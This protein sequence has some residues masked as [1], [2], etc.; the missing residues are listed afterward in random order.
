MMITFVK[1][2]C[3][4]IVNLIE[5]F[6]NVLKEST[7][8][9]T[10]IKQRFFLLLNTKEDV[11]KYVGNQTDLVSIDFH[12]IFPHTMKVNGYQHSAHHRA[13]SRHGQGHRAGS[14]HGH[15]L[16]CPPNQNVGKDSLTHFYDL[17]ID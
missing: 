9:T 7:L 6:L 1:K 15:R 12:S 4:Y 10:F 11:L 16:S 13:G 14:R 2:K 17:C 3:I 5:V 8:F